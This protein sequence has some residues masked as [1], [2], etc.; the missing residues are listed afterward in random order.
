MVID[1]A[2]D[3]TAPTGKFECIF[4]QTITSP[5]YG[6]NSE[7]AVKGHALKLDYFYRGEEFLANP[8]IC[9]DRDIESMM[10]KVKQACLRRCLRQQSNKKET[11]QEKA[12]IEILKDDSFDEDKKGT[13]SRRES[14]LSKQINTLFKNIEVSVNSD[15][16]P[17]PPP[18]DL[19][20]FS[21]KLK[22][23]LKKPIGELN[24]L[25]E[26]VEIE[27][28]ATK[29]KSV[30]PIKSCDLSA[31]FKHTLEIEALPLKG[32][33]VI[34]PG[35]SRNYELTEVTKLIEHVMNQL[36]NDDD[37]IGTTITHTTPKKNPKCEDNIDNATMRFLN[38]LDKKEKEYHGK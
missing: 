25:P 24:K 12:I 8:G 10:N 15:K 30:A 7:L 5:C 19:P 34:K 6:V 9:Q 16:P 37:N 4:R 13:L 32:P 22:L 11:T 1:R 35:K 3:P 27:P 2:T 31:V 29:P 18:E 17:P 36:S 21:P 23:N 14:V 26:T 33:L 20:P 38:F 28:S